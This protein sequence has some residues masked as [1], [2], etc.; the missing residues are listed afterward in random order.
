MTDRL[1]TSSAVLLLLSTATPTSAAAG[2]SFSNTLGDHAVLQAP[3]TVWGVGTPGSTVTTTVSG[4]RGRHPRA[5]LPTTIVG[6]DGIWRYG[7]ECDPQ[8][9]RPHT[10]PAPCRAA[11]LNAVLF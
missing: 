2:F 11:V 6:A 1:L 10:A 3:I 9:T 4:G 5:S 7:G 8:G